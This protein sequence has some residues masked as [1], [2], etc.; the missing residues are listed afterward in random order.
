MYSAVGDVIRENLAS[1]ATRAEAGGLSRSGGSD[2]R[3][4]GRS[5]PQAP[6]VT[7]VVKPDE[8]CVDD[9]LCPQKLRCKPSLGA[10]DGAGKTGVPS[11]TL[12][13]PQALPPGYNVIGMAVVLLMPKLITLDVMSVK[14]KPVNV[15]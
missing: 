15:L 14:L 6:G 10:T 11:P 12:S 8:Y 4:A 9:G 1:P 3:E 2:V 13:M 5:P 7:L